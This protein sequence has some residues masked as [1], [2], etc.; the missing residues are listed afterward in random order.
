MRYPLTIIITLP[1]YITV[2]NMITTPPPGAE[3]KK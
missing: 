3:L 1:I 2:V